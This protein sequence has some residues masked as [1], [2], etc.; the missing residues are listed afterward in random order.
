[1]ALLSRS[2]TICNYVLRSRVRADKPVWVSEN[3]SRP[4]PWPGGPDEQMSLTWT[5]DQKN[6]HGNVSILNPQFMSLSLGFT[7]T[8][9]P[10]PGRTKGLGRTQCLLAEAC[11]R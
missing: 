6:L 7:L 9:A 11:P 8:G 10:S 5:M 1:M 2:L 3:P 4:L